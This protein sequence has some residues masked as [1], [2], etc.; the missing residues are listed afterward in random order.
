MSISMSVFAPPV[1]PDQALLGWYD[2]HAR[3]LPWRTP[4]A[5]VAEGIR[6]NPYHVWLSEVM[7][8]QT[9]VATVKAYYSRFLERWPRIQDLAT[10]Q[11][12]EVLSEW[13]GLGYY[14]R[15][16]NLHRC[17][18]VVVRE[19]QG[20][21]PSEESA[22]RKLPG[23]GDYTAAAIAAIAFG[24]CAVVVDGNVERVISRYFALETPLPHSRLEIRKLT[25]QIT[26]PRRA[27]DFAQ[28]MMDLG[29]GTCTPRKPDCLL[30]PLRGSCGALKKGLAEV[31]PYKEKRKSKP[32]R[33]AWAYVLLDK[34]AQDS[35]AARVYLRRRLQKG[36][37]GGMLEVPSGPWEEVGP[38]HD[39]TW[40]GLLPWRPLKERARHSFSHFDFE[41]SICVGK[42]SEMSDKELFDN[43][44][45]KEEGQW[46]SLR[47]LD[48]KAL[49][50]AMMKILKLSLSALP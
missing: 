39:P 41:I 34:R 1:A 42:L 18:Q 20:R 31:L 35:Q 32:T 14:A 43:L 28:A 29:A 38:N 12:D 36:M 44:S 2:R 24:Q 16:R 21:L 27:G 23:I 26:P 6:P 40:Q 19:H 11:Q 25:G 7:L 33:R 15:A 10:A 50:T 9:T 22:L 17:A 46:V 37:L 45:I 47:D 5:A 8:Q 30:C 13:A 49:P 3:L 4:P 48:H